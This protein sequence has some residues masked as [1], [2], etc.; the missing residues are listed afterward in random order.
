[1]M[2]AVCFT[3]YCWSITFPRSGGAYVALS[4]T[5]GVAPAFILGVGEAFVLAMYAGIASTM[6][7]NFGF[8]QLFSF[9]GILF[10]WEPGNTIGVWLN[11]KHGTFIGA[12]IVLSLGTWLLIAGMRKFFLVQKIM[13]IIAGAGFLT[14]LGVLMAHTNE[15][16]VANFNHFMKPLNYSGVIEAAKQ[17]GWSNPGFNWSESLQAFVWPLLAMLGALQS[18][19]IGGEVKQAGRNQAVGMIGSVIVAAVGCVMFAIFMNKSIGY[20]FQGA[21]A[22]NAF[23]NPEFSTPTTPW[24][25]LLVSILGGNLPLTLIVCV[26][27]IAWPYFWIPAQLTYPARSVLAWSFDR[28]IPEFFSRVSKTRFTPT[29]AILTVWLMAVTGCALIVYGGWGIIAWAMLLPITWGAC[30]VAGIFFPFTRKSM[31]KKSPVA[32]WRV[33]KVPLMSI[34]GAISAIFFGVT[35][36]LLWNDPVAAGHSPQTLITLGVLLLAGLVLY[37]I[38]YYTRRRQGIRLERV[39]EEIPIE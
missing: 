17:S 33:G 32:R 38:I 7:I 20:D 13:M 10:G 31:F 21:I 8:A 3:F 9:T 29:Y 35:F 2:L 28:V 39:A 5:F 25:S 12:F 24:A 26:S 27:F 15:T 18:I 36:V 19:S 1:M 6:S 4:R 14:A 30:M 34:A 22:W 37:P 23:E 16:F 11:S